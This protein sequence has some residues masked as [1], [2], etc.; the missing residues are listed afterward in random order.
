MKK[1]IILI[2]ATL[3]VSLGAIATAGIVSNIRTYSTEETDALVLKLQQQIDANKADLD[4]QIKTLT[5]YYKNKDAELLA[6]ITENQKN[7]SVLDAKYAEEVALLEESDSE[8]QQALA[9]LTAEY[10]NKVE[11]LTAADEANA[12][13]L[14]EL[15]TTYEAKVNKLEAADSQN[16]DEIASLHAEYTAKVEELAKAD[17]S[18]ANALAKLENEYNA[19]VAALEMADSDNAK[20]L[21]D[22]TDEYEEQV[23]TLKEADKAND[24]ALAKLREDYEAKVSELAQADTNNKQALDDLT[25]EYNAK[26]AE[27]TNADKANVEALEKL[28]AE[29][30]AKVEALQKVD[31]DNADALEKLKTEYTTKVSELQTAINNAN[32]TIESNKTEL[33][34]KIASLTN[35][36]T[37]KMTEI[38]LLLETIKSKATIQ[39][40][41]IAELA[42]EIVNLQNAT[43]ITAIEFKDNGD[44]LITF[45]DGSTKTVNAPKKHEHTFGAYKC[46]TTDATVNC[47]NRLFYRI[48]V[49][50]NTIEW[51][52]GTYSDHTWITV[53][54]SSTCQSQGY[55]TKTC[56][57]CGEVEIEN[58][59]NK[60]DHA[61]ETTYSYDNDYHWYD[62]TTCDDIKDKGEHIVNDSG[63]CTV[64]NNLVGATAGVVYTLSSDGTYYSVTDYQGTAAEV[65]VVNTY[66]QKPVKEISANAFSQSQITRIVIN[67]GVTSIGKRAFL[68][69]INLT[70][71][72]I[73]NSVTNIDD[74]AFQSCTNLCNIIIG[75]K[76]T[77]IGS[78]VFYGCNKLTKITIPDSVTSIGSYAFYNCSSLQYTKY[79][80][81]H[82][83]GNDSNPYVVLVKGLNRTT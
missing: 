82:Y 9:D 47:E 22:L 63:L 25:E 77:T 30:N 73:P 51:K 46:F 36:Y 5:E 64:C 75:N 54:T 76:V 80:N 42:E 11:E 21:S 17:E 12:N 43:R 72:I 13:A 24:D 31:K 26:V 65:C 19:K 44:L 23:K 2:I 74:Q 67:S 68:G 58:Y 62:C 61:W 55:D 49:D 71:I 14:S 53:T 48:C 32:S 1:T 38:D 33:E 20:A 69:C 40:G 59:T 8:N 34:D 27:L 70:S 83:L 28:E 78:D 35:V 79:D 16:K 41:K 81:A 6:A 56:K 4:A 29:Y 66:N 57:N 39:D 52:N 3:V 15:K 50:C 7:I 45:G 18:N 10:N 37:A 60:V